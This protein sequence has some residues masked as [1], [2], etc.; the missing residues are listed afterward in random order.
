MR[1]IADLVRHGMLEL[2]DAARGADSAVVR[3]RSRL[4][5]RS[6]TKNGM[7]IRKCRAVPVTLNASSLVTTVPLGIPMGITD[8]FG[9]FVRWETL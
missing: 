9:G 3:Q 4:A 6:L 8:H 2:I 5:D 1:Q 7:R